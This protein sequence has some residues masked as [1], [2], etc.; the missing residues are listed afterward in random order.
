M[1]DLSVD[2]WRGSWRTVPFHPGEDGWRAYDDSVPVVTTTLELL[3]EHGPLGPV[4]WR[5]GRA[6]RDLGGP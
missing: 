3:A 1:A 4:W 5:F 6:G 2:C